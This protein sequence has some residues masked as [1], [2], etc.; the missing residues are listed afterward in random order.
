MLVV[1]SA[2]IKTRKAVNVFAILSAVALVSVALRVVWF[3]IR[4]LWRPDAL[5]SQESTFF[6]TQLGNYAAC[7]L[8]GDAMTSTAGLMGFPWMLQK[9]ITDGKAVHSSPFDKPLS[10]LF[11]VGCVNRK[12]N[13]IR[14]TDRPLKPDL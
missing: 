2:D 3:A 10:T 5:E 7:L 13:Y 12:V 8:F 9:G 14:A 1:S 11:K 4:K 6:R